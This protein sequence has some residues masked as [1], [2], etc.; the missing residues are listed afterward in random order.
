MGGSCH[1]IICHKI[2][3]KLSWK[4]MQKFSLSARLSRS[5][6]D[7]KKIFQWWIFRSNAC[8]L[9]AD[10][11]T[12]AI[13]EI[14]SVLAHA[15]NYVFD[16]QFSLLNF[17]FFEEIFENSLARVKLRSQKISPVASFS[18]ITK[19][20]SHILLHKVSEVLSSRVDF[21]LVRRGKI[22]VRLFPSDS[23]KEE[24]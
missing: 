12:R 4:S 13:M 1:R 6:N 2:S 16:F 17:L 22:L 18:K 9:L 23:R 5:S 10:S 11:S 7:M 3:Q 8:F 24:K 14:F 20:F 19:T 15:W 21:V